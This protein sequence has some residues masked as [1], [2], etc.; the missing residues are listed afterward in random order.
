MS[1]VELAAV[2][3]AVSAGAFV[4]AVTGMG[5]PLVAIPVMA[6]VVGVEDAVV[7][8]APANV[9][10]NGWLVW[11][12]RHGR[13]GAPP[14]VVFVTAGAAGA[15]VGVWLLS[16]LDGRW[17]SG[18]LAAAVLVYVVAQVRWP[19]RRLPPRAA[20]RLA[21]GAGAVAGVA[22][23]AAGISG[24]IVGAYVHSL[25]LPRTVHVFSVTLVF[26]VLGAAQLVSILAL[27]LM[28]IGRTGGAALA[29]VPVAA[30]T[31]VGTRVGDRLDRAVFDR[32]VLGVLAAAGVTLA[33]QA[34]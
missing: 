27:G 10:A 6:L 20:R 18:L 4:K 12:Y 26:L 7:V 5:L 9:A 31:L 22:Q 17:L 28:T 11:R 32:V 30:A 29:A 14:L 8:I 25:R 2:L 16:R 23:G 3:L 15:V 34:V 33:V 13:T 1:P 21:P 19:E 24:P